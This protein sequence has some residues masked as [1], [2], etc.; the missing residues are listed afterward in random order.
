MEEAIYTNSK[1]CNPKKF[2]LELNSGVELNPCIFTE[3]PYSFNNNWI[4]MVIEINFN[5]VNS[6]GSESGTLPVFTVMLKD[7]IR[8]GKATVL[9]DHAVT[10]TSLLC[11]GKGY[12]ELNVSI[13]GVHIQGGR[14]RTIL[15]ENK[16]NGNCQ[17][18]LDPFNLHFSH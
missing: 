2:R 10:L 5:S 17:S 4:R 16:V 1:A 15:M 8:S 11:T 6:N 14:K 18:S 3:P 7:F 13:F 12:G 9:N